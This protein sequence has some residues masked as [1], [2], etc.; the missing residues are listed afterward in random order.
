MELIG[1]M[2]SEV[3]VAVCRDWTPG[4]LIRKYQSFWN[5]L[6]FWGAYQC[7]GELRPKVL[8]T[9]NHFVW[10]LAT[11]FELTKLLRNCPA[12]WVTC[13]PFEELTWVFEEI[14]RLPQLESIS[15]GNCSTVNRRAAKQSYIWQ[16][17]R[18]GKEHEELQLRSTDLRRRRWNSE[19]I[20]RITKK[21]LFLSGGEYLIKCCLWILK[22]TGDGI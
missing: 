5:F 4:S 8:G 19:W 12:F 22:I 21:L 9:Y 15:V 3:A 13:Q 16:P 14:T 1:C 17:T 20:Y 6:I 7:F 2:K 10:N 11:Y 18:K